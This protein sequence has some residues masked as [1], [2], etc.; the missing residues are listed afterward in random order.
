[1]FTYFHC[2]MPETW[3]A[4]EKCG[5][6][7]QNAGIRFSQSIDLEDHM[8][9][10]RLAAPGG[11]LFDLISEQ[12]RPFY[13]DRLQGGCYIEDYPYDPALIRKIRSVL[14]ENFW[15][16]QMHEWMSNYSGDL[17]KL[18]RGNCA[19]WNAEEIRQAIYRVYP[20]YTRH[21][22]LESMN[23]EEMEEFGCPHDLTEFLQNSQ[24]L[25]A[26][27]QKATDGLL[28]PCDSSALSYPMELALGAKRLMPEIGAQTPHTRIQVAFARGMAKAYRIPFGTYYEPWGG[29]RPVSTCCYHKEGK[30]EWN[31]GGNDFPY[32]ANG[33]NGGS[34]R[35]MQRRMHLYS[36]FA[37]ASFMAEEWGMCNTFYDWHDFELTPYGEIKR[38]FIRLTEKYPNIGKPLVPIAIV[39]PRTLQALNIPELA[40]ADSNTHFGYPLEPS[41]IPTFR[42]MYTVLQSLMGASGKMLGTETRSLLNCCLPDALDI[43][44]ENSV[45]AEEYTYLVDLTDHAAFAAAHAKQCIKPEEVPVRL[46]PLLPCRVEG[47]AMKQFTDAGN[48]VYYV[49]LTN[50]SGVERSAEQGEHLLPDAAETLHLTCRGGKHLTPLEGNSTCRFDGETAHI[51]IPAGGWFMGRIA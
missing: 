15:G 31:I 20:N 12:H 45:R 16:F 14:G 7:N 3:E 38:D 19:A 50:N 40:Q 9:F 34:S 17:R 44:H 18:Q 42:N 48:G 32:K 26:R 4:Q 47:N 39:L 5:L 46:A 36:Y 43:V 33:E 37:G 23:A 49:L 35:S 41:L 8:K 2:Y 30:N 29:G 28:I 51:E 10:N 24:K 13:I 21:L 11:A 22:F 25:F 6:I 1:M 27:R